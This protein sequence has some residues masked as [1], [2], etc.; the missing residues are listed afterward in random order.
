MSVDNL[1]LKGTTLLYTSIDD[2]THVSGFIKSAPGKMTR[3]YKVV[4]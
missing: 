3:P 4:P 1:L 2:L